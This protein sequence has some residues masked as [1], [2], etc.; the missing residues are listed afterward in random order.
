MKR[1]YE[2]VDTILDYVPMGH[3][4]VRGIRV[5]WPLVLATIL[6]GLSL[7]ATLFAIREIRRNI[8]NRNRNLKHA[9]QKHK[10]SAR[11]QNR[12]YAKKNQTWRTLEGKRQGK[13]HHTKPLP[14]PPM[15][16]EGLNKQWDKLHD[17]LE[18]MLKFGDMLIELDDYVDNSFIFDGDTIVGRLPGMK[19]FLEKHCPHIGYPTAM[20]YRSLALKA[21]EVAKSHGKLQKILKECTTIFELGKRLDTYLDIKYRQRKFDSRRPIHRTPDNPQPAIFSMRE[22]A[23]SAIEQLK[24]PA[25]RQRFISAMRELVRE[26]SVS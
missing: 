17:S 4:K 11:D 15:F 20:R 6:L 24:K 22:Q 2:T 8:Y 1:Y 19:G 26:I 13:Y 21:H 18:E 10:K 23:H 12:K 9:S 5:V 16:A 14:L 25:E 7:E 3:D